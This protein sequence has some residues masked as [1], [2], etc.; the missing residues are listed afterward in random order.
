MNE[1][2]LDLVLKISILN[3]SEY[4]T[5]WRRHTTCHSYQ[6]SH[7]HQ[8][9]NFKYYKSF[10]SNCL[11]PG[12]TALKINVRPASKAQTLP[13][14]QLQTGTEIFLTP[15]LILGITKNLL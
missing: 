9:V 8:R 5:I 3:M 15:C 12:N 10:F 14:A 13:K 7:K 4:E 6:T 1:W 2:N 11:T